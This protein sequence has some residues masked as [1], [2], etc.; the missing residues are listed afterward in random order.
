MIAAYCHGYGFTGVVFRFVSILGERYTH[1]H[2]FDFYRALK[3]RPD[4]PARARRRPPGEVLPL[5]AGLR[6][7]HPHRRWRAHDEPG[8]RASTTSAA[9][10]RSSSTTR[11][12]ASRAHL[13]LDPEIEHTGGVRGWAGD[14]PLILLDCTKIRA[15]GWAPAA[16]DRRGDRAHAR[17]VR[18]APRDRPGDEPRMSVIFTRAPLRLSLGGG[19]TDLPSYYDAPR[20]VPRRRRDRQVHLH[21]RRT[22]SSSAATG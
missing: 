11:S 9:T 16:D 18:G 6:G 2:V 17:L 5:R 7:R 15:L 4:A 1:G 13:G 19:G 20:R 12:P 22:R 10:R 14:S 3:T 21:D 8:L